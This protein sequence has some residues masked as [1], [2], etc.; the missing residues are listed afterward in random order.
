MLGPCLFILYVNDMSDMI[1]SNIR[2]IA[3]DTIMNLTFSNQTDRQTD[4]SKLK[5]WERSG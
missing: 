4:I 1:E 2:L 3:N 5:T